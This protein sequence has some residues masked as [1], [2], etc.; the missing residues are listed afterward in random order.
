MWCCFWDLD[1]AVFSCRLMI[2]GIV[3]LWVC[4]V[5]MMFLDLS[6]IW[7]TFAGR[8]VYCGDLLLHVLC[9]CGSFPLDLVWDTAL[10]VD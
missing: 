9:G 1:F 6:L 5:M 7:V 10:V 4:C 3:L 8:G 2:L